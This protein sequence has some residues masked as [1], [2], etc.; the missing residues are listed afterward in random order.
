MDGPSGTYFAC[1]TPDGT[2]ARDERL[3]HEL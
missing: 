1:F 3:R 2:Q